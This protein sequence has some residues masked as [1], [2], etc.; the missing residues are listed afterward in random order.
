MPTPTDWAAFFPT[1]DQQR[2]HAIVQLLQVPDAQTRTA[3][4]EAG[5]VLGQPLTGHAYLAMLRRPVRTAAPALKAIRWVGPLTLDD[6][7]APE[8]KQPGRA[9]WARR[10]AGRVE[11]VVKLFPDGNLAT[12]TQWAK[13]LGGDLLGEAPAVSLF[14]VSLPD[15][16]ERD[17]ASLDDVRYIEPMPAP[18]EPESDRARG[19]VH[20]D[21]G[22]IPA[23][24]PN[25]N[26]VVVG[27][28]DVGNASST[29]PDLIGRCPQGDPR[30]YTPGAHTTMTAGM[31]AGDGSQSSSQPPA[32]PNQPRASPNQWRGLAPGAACLSYGYGNNDASGSATDAVTNYLNDVTKAVQNDSV[33]VLNNSWGTSGCSTFAYGSYTGRAPFLDGVVTGSL[34][35]PVPIVFSAGNERSGYAVVMGNTT[36]I[37]TDCIVHITTPFANYTTLNHPKSAKNVIVVGAI[38]SFNNAMSEYSSWGPTLD[39]RIKPDVVASGHHHGSMMNGMSKLDNPFGS[40]TG[41]ANEQDYRVPIFNPTFVYG[42]FSQTSSAAAIASGGLALLLD[43]WHRTFPSRADPLPSTLRALL[44]HNARDLDDATTTWYKPG[45][46]YASGYGLVQI[47]ETEQS[48]ERGEAVEGSVAHRSEVPFTLNVPNGMQRLKV[49]LAWDDPPAIE[50]ANPA[51]IND[52]DLVVTDPSGARHYPWTLDPSNPTTAAVRTKEDRVNNLEQVIVDAGPAGAWTVTVRGTNVIQGPQ[53]FSLVRSVSPLLLP[54]P[55]NLRIQ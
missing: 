34:G 19:H 37:K 24:R 10:V 2:V 4:A 20:A 25:G 3:L 30:L 28:F 43:D 18:G 31:I 40:P 55:T 16:R 23:G 26:R 11:L 49:T 7:I 17:L 22:A 13:N 32:S 38:D 41:N 5:I 39:G 35:R 27:I 15:G 14:T 44:V 42:W 6:K 33:V 29:H 47:A 36:V 51:L 1:P 48:L 8:L 54:P 45:P 53:T 12:A 21:V 46:D 50:N 52:L 9:P